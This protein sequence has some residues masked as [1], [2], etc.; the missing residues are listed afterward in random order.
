M[1]VWTLPSYCWIMEPILTSQ[2]G[3]V[4]LTLMHLLLHRVV[5]IPKPRNS[6]FVGFDLLSILIPINCLYV[7][8]LYARILQLK[9]AFWVT[10]WASV[11]KL[12]Q[13]PAF[14]FCNCVK[15]VTILHNKNGVTRFGNYNDDRCVAADFVGCHSLRNAL[16]KSTSSLSLFLYKR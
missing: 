2:H 4:L 11:K 13:V 3:S 12:V 5:V 14:N 10:V 15:L 6:V 7:C 1:A 16:M 8:V 9:S